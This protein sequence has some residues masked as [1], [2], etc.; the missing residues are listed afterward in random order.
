MIVLDTNVVSEIMKPPPV[1]STKVFDWLRAYPTGDVFTTTIA[2]AEVLAGIAMLPQGKR[3]ADLERAAE[4]V[5][6]TVFPRR[7]LPFDEAAAPVYSDLVTLR[8]RRALSFEPL[9]MQI[10]AIA[11]SRGMTVATRNVFDF[12]HCGLDVINPWGD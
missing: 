10:G 3:K 9:D 7:I 1:R 4:R 2:L 11:K 5:F 6:S 12:E 8:R